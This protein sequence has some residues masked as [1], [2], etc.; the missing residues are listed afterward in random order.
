VAITVV[1]RHTWKGKGT[2]IGRGTVWGN[3]YTH[4]PIENT[5][6]Q[7]QVAT[8]EEAIEKYREWAWEQWDDKNSDFHRGVAGLIGLYLAGEDIIL[9]CSCKP[10]ACHGDL[11]KDMVEGLA[12]T[13]EAALAGGVPSKE[14]AIPF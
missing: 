6:A 10:A 8:R 7:F 14:D 13:G 11:I 3:P 9:A 2:Y 12:F 4:L 1:N 5:Q